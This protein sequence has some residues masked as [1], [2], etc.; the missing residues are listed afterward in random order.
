MEMEMTMEMTMEKAKNEAF[1][2]CQESW[3]SSDIRA[4]VGRCLHEQ[5]YSP[6][7]A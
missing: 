4:I 1:R 2:S 5:S 3:T 6:G 7:S